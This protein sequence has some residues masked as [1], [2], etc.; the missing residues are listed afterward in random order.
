MA[1]NE[2]NDKVDMSRPLQKAITS[3]TRQDTGHSA[4]SETTRGDAVATTKTKG[5]ISMR[6]APSPPRISGDTSTS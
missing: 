4:Y 6:Y 5:E 3:S 1:M 2:T